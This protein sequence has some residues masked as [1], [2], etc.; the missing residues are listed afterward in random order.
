MTVVTYPLGKPR[1][2]TARGGDC[3]ARDLTQGRNVHGPHHFAATTDLQI[4]NGLLRLTI[5]AA[6]IAPTI[7]VECW[8]AAITATTADYFVDVFA[9][10]FPGSVSTSSAA[11]VSM[12]TVT[13]DG[14]SVTALLTGVQLRSVKPSAVRV[15]LIAPAIGDA[16]ITLRQGFRAFA[17]QHGSTRGTVS[18]AR[19]LSMAGPP[20]LAGSVSS[21]RVTETDPPATPGIYRFIASLDVAFGSGFALT[22]P[23]GYSYCRF[24]AGVGTTATLDTPADIHA[25]LADA[26]RSRLE[27]V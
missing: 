8:S 11:W 2:A 20:T 22:S 25:Q 17:A 23:A 10:T 3:R 6:G 1:A 9:D 21:G 26:S 15:R 19:R 4:C 27:V 14:P 7:T 13:L 16:Y 5:G 12:G 24:G 18:I